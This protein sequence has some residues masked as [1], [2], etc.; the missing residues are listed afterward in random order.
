MIA[1]SH[2][3]CKADSK[4]RC[5]EKQAKARE[6]RARTVYGCN[7]LLLNDM[8]RIKNEKI[9]GKCMDNV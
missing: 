5:P 7:I 1:H 3:E 9:L 4:K 2:L 8:L 6:G